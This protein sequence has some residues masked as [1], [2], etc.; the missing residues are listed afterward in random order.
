[1]TLGFPADCGIYVV[2]AGIN[3][4]QDTTEDTED[5]QQYDEQRVVGNGCTSNAE[6]RKRID[7]LRLRFKL[8][9]MREG[10][11]KVWV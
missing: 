10:R 11:G 6:T 4:Q 9:E 8:S 1:M 3:R 7:N 5:E 2:K